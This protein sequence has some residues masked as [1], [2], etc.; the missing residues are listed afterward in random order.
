MYEIKWRIKVSA[1]PVSI[2]FCDCYNDCLV[3]YLA[4]TIESRPCG[5]EVFVV[6]V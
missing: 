3:V 2:A 4:K 6:Q 5:G 1:I